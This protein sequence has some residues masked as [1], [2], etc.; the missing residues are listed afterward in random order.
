MPEEGVIGRKI[1]L[2]KETVIL[3]LVLNTLRYG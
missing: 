3:S 2:F 1:R